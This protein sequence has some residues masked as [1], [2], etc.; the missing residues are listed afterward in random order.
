[1][2][3]GGVVV[4]HHVDLQIRRYVGIDL[5]EK[6]QPLSV[7]MARLALGDDAA[8]QNVEGRKQRVVPWRL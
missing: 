1:M 5:L 8:V 4:Q 6:L 3:V 2:F 7:P